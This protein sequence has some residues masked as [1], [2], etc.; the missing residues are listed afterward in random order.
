MH[1][2]SD[3]WRLEALSRL[4]ADSAFAAQARRIGNLR[5]W[6]VSDPRPAWAE[7]ITIVIRDAVVDALEG[8]D[9]QPDGM[10]RASYDT[11]LRLFRGQLSPKR[12]AMTRKLRG[13]GLP[14]LLRNMGLLNALLDVVR[15]I[16]LDDPE[17]QD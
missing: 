12:A 13:K 6:I 4:R 8:E 17:S 5:V 11:W 10:A 3:E 15:V 2:L 14:V 16:P 7:N 1:F 9:G